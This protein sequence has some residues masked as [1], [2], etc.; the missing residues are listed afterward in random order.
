MVDVYGRDNGFGLK[1]NEIVG[2]QIVSVPLSVSQTIATRTLWR[3]MLWLVGFSLIT[4]ALLNA[5]F[6]KAVIR[7]MV[8]IS[9][10]ALELS[11]GNLYVS[12]VPAHGKDEISVL[13]D[14]LN[15]VQRSLVKAIKALEH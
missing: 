5:V 9:A 4:G 2:A 8:R 14:S 3:L 15:R 12:E 1:L 11:K 10:A 7:P 13:A 6:V